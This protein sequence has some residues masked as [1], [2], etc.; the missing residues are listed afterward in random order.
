MSFLVAT[1]PQNV[2]FIDIR[3][4]SIRLSW[5]T[6]TNIKGK[7]SG[8]RV[9]LTAD[10]VCKVEVVF[11]CTDCDGAVRLLISLY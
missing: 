7:L 9:S 4:R 5:M 6:P 11:Q 8:Y 3:S 1:L 2:T 10:S